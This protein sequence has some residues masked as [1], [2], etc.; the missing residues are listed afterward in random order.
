MTKQG[1]AFRQGPRYTCLL[2]ELAVL[3]GFLHGFLALT[4]ARILLLLTGLLTATLLLLAGLLARGLVL[5]AR[6]LV[7][8]AHVWDLP[9]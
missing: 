2:F 9:C 5:L 4:A 6:R 1:P 8:V 7:L 3:F